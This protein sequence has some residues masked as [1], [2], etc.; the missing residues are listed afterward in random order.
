MCRDERVGPGEGRRLREV[1][2]MAANVARGRAFD[3]R[4]LVSDGVAVALGTDVT[5]LDFE[6]GLEE[7]D[8]HFRFV[9]F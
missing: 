8:V 4:E 7:G 3:R 6:H 9:K 5:V 1:S 2:V